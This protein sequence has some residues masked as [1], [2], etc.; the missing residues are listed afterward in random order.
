MK[1]KRV[2]YLLGTGATQAEINLWNESIRILMN[3]IRYGM[4]RKINDNKIK[5]LEPVKNELVNDDINIE[6]LITL[7]ENSGTDEH[8]QI[9]KNLKNIFREVIQEKIK[10]LNDKFYPILLSALIDMHE[11]KENDEELKGILTLNYEEVLDKAFQKVKKGVNYVI[12]LKNKHDCLKIKKSIK[13]LLKLHGS[14]NWKN[15]YPITLINEYKIKESED[16]LWIPPGFIKK[17]EK[18]PF[19]II[20]G[21]AQEIL[22]CDILRIIGCS[23]SITE[24]ELIS[25][26]YSAQKLN[27]KNDDYLIEIIDSIDRGK[28]IQKDY[29]YLRVKTIL[30]I[31]EVN[32]SLKESY[33]THN[34]EALKNILNTDKTN[35]LDLWLKSKG[36]ALKKKGVNISTNKKIFENY[37]N[38]VTNENTS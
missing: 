20:W 6:H 7:Y 29:A 10:K 36:D 25:L 3:D 9:A 2:V 38:G 28:K 19:N 4:L 1:K 33:P 17:R 11:I 5:V 13:P 12:K 23:L 34:D 16:F 24:W 32:D 37:I 30:E 22:D 15:E 18:Y 14:F 35:F 31:R 27:K 26:L 8:Y 21:T